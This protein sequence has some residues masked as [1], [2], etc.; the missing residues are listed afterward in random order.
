M[1]DEVLQ[2]FSDTWGQTALLWQRIR[3]SILEKEGI[4]Q[5]DKRILYGL[6]KV[7]AI[8][9]KDLAKRVVLE[10]SSLT[11]SLDRLEKQKL[12]VRVTNPKDKRYI[13]ISLTRSGLVK[14]KAIKRQSL[15]LLNKL[16]SNISD[17]QV[18][19]TTNVLKQLQNTM[20]LMIETENL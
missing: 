6:Y 18:K 16:L 4:T 2:S 3:R 19:R 7:E 10:H 17:D 15:K 12:I 20:K 14:T 5:A 9:K 1:N 11:R 13:K 8:T